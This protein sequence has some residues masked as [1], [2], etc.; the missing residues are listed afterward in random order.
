MSGLTVEDWEKMEKKFQSVHQRL[1]PIVKEL[2]ET[3]GKID[4]HEHPQTI[5]PKAESTVRVH[6]ADKH[7]LAK[8]IGIVVGIATVASIAFQVVLAFWPKH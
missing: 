4:H 6:V 3:R 7:D 2:T 5:C 8:F 1:D